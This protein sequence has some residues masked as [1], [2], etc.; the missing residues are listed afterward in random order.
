[1]VCYLN[2]MKPVKGKEEGERKRR[3]RK[4]KKKEKGKEEG[5]R[6]RRRRKEKKK[7]KGKEEGERKRRR[8][9][10]NETFSL[11]VPSNVPTTRLHTAITISLYTAEIN[12]LFNHPV[13]EHRITSSATI[14]LIMTFRLKCA[15]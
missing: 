12:V 14:S 8:R 9:K 10:E 2:D 13:T 11:S 15:F 6:K 1:M 7:E 5:E 3:R 4:E